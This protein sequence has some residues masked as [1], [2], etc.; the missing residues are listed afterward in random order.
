MISNNFRYGD[1]F[2]TNLSPT[3]MKTSEM[4]NKFKWMLKSFTVCTVLGIEIAVKFAIYVLQTIH[5]RVNVSTILSLTVKE[6]THRGY[7]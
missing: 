3:L 2:A 6:K 4:I 7:Q 5:E 1:N